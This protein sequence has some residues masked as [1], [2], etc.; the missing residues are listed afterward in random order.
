[1]SR[2]IKSAALLIGAVAVITAGAT[3]AFFSDTETSS[4]NT[5]TAGAIDLKID[6]ESYY[7][8]VATSTTSWELTDLT[9]QKFF[10]FLDLKPDDWGEDTISIHV[11]TNDTY[12]C[13]DAKLTSNEENGINEPE[14][15]AG[16]ITAGPG[17][18]ELAALVEFIAWPDD[19]DNVLEVGETLIGQGPASILTLNATATVPLADSDENIWDGS[20]GPI[21]G[22]TTY[23]IGK[24][25][26]FGDIGAAPIAQDNS[27]TLMSPAGNN[28]GNGLSGEPEDGGITC[29]GSVIGN[30][31]QTDS[32]TMDVSFR[33][34]QARNNPNFQCDGSTPDPERA[35][36]TLVKAVNNAGEGSA[37]GAEWTLTATGPTPLSG[38]SGS[39]AVTNVEVG[40]G[41]YVL[42]ES[43]GI[44]G[45]GASEYSCVVNG[46]AAVLGNNLNLADG[47]TATCT[48]TNTVNIC[49][50]GVQYADSAGAFSQGKQKEGD[51][52]LANRSLPSAAFGTPQTT[53]ADSDVG[54]PV[55]S[56]VSLGF[57]GTSSATASLVLNFDNNVILNGPGADL[58]VYEVTGGVYPDELI[59]IE[60]SQDGIVWTLLAAAAAR[61]EEVDLASL[62]WAKY[63]RVTDINNPT[64]FPADAD[65]YDVDAMEALNC[66]TVPTQVQ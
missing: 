54:F 24:A 60:A 2:I 29:D 65:G 46:G 56:F 8:G 36:I 59:K 43:S 5:F 37:T 15:G 6:N 12:L 63:V 40:A 19:G 48:I 39:G 35:T 49:S 21:D 58:K 52:V 33:A 9:I 44:P 1:M 23:Y 62:A 27:G 17:Q 30:A 28:N 26:C 4:G 51:P 31:S 16:D 14:A 55:G 18:G 64:L 20:G 34:V 41:A 66:A 11:D 7:N 53:G 50:A 45:Y 61:D 3:G 13:L 42:G 10:N 32:L 47:D 38:A 57:V 22:D 25:W